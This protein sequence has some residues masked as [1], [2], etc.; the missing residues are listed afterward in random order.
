M[1]SPE[2]CFVDITANKEGQI[3]PSQIPFYW[4]ET[5]HKKEK[6]MISDTVPKQGTTESNN[7]R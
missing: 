1:V 4:M 6:E 2:Q 7:I 5:Q 3:P